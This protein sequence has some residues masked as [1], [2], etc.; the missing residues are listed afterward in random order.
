M[1]NYCRNCGEKLTN[2]Q[3]CGKC[4][5]KVISKRV[6]ELDKKL[7]FKYIVVFF[8]LL[9]IGI[10]IFLL[11]IPDDR[12]FDVYLLPLY[13]PFF[14]VTYVAIAKEKLRFSKFF[15][16]LFWLLLL[17]IFILGLCFLFRLFLAFYKF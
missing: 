13:Y 8:V 15:N 9:I 6:G 4:G 3:V 17:I 11:T 10:V 5:T 16:F 14:L 12:I 2:S 7:A 1:N